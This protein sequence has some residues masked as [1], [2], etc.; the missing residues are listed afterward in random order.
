MLE[1]LAHRGNTDGPSP[2]T[3]NR[4]PAIA[5]ALGRGWGVEIDVRRAADDRFYV[6]HDPRPWSEHSSADGFCELARLFPGRTIALNVKELGY[7]DALLMY[8]DAQG[9]LNDVFLFDM[10]LIE[11]TPGQTARLLRR[12]HS[13]VRLAARVSDHREPVERAL[14]ITMASVIWLDEFDQLWCTSNDV[15]RLK[16]EGRT[17]YAVS[18]DLHGFPLDVTW[19]RWEELAAWG[20]D[21]ICTDYPGALEEV[22]GRLRHGAHA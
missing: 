12:L 21:G 7:E 17:V 15:R 20:V 14:E 3:E 6:S 5:A 4:L 1:I 11:P 22:L 18:P 8:L 13:G 2:A 19:R 10:E 9:V 16:D